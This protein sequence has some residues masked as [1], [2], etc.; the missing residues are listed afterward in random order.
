MRLI[1]KSSRP[2]PEVRALV[3]FGMKGLQHKGITVTVVDARKKAWDGKI[4][5]TGWANKSRGKILIRI[6]PDWCYPYKGWKRHRNSPLNHDHQNWQESVVAL[7]AH[8]GKHIDLSW[9]YYD[10]NMVSVYRKDVGHYTRKNHQVEMACEAHE[11]W[12]LDRYRESL[13]SSR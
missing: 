11:R 9:E 12:V 3:R 7:A 1:N 2:T 6:A 13:L 4:H 5:S 10:R 8:E